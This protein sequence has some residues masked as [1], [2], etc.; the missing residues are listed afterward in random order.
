MKKTKMFL[1]LLCA[2]M[3]WMSPAASVA[4]TNRAELAATPDDQVI[5]GTVEDA[6]GPM[7]GATVKVAGTNN[8]TV[9]DFDGKFHLKCKP[10][11][12]LEVSYVGYSTKTVKAQ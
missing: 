2:G 3:M 5:S 8:G 9:T 12:L 7:I 10:G 11:D 1:C 6:A 4:G